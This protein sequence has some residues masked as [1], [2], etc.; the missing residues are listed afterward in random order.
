MRHS[1][2]TFI[3]C[4]MVDSP[5]HCWYTDSHAR[6]YSGH[7]DFVHWLTFIVSVVWAVWDFRTMI[8]NYYP[9]NIWTSEENQRAGSFNWP[10]EYWLVILTHKSLGFLTHKWCCW[11]KWAAIGMWLPIML[12]MQ[13]DEFQFPKSC[14]CCSGTVCCKQLSQVTI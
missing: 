13:T 8:S 9:C 7:S 2:S 6:E 10:T 12:H 4:N 1:Y 14:H 3:T 11:P 5:A